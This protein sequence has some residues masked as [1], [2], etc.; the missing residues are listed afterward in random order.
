[1]NFRL[2]HS[3]LAGAVIAACTH[4]PQAIRETSTSTPQPN[5]VVRL[6]QL[7]FGSDARFGLCV[8][9]ACPSRTPKTLATVPPEPI[10]PVALASEPEPRPVPTPTPTTRERSETITIEFPFSGSTLSSEARARLAA[11]FGLAKSASRIVIRGRTD[12]VGVEVAND[13]IALARAVAARN[14]IRQNLPS[15]V[16]TIVIESKGSCCYVA[17]NDSKAGRARNRRIEIEFTFAG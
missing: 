13:R 10:R 7:H 4:A 17:D 8:E 14:F 9:P 5:P 15:A 11:S 12:S 16:N 6:V 2:V 1:M 3:V